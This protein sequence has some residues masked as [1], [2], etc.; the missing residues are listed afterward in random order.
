MKLLSET[1]LQALPEPK[2]LIPG[3]IPERSFVVM[4]GEPGCG[5]TFV[6]LS[7]A[8]SI[9]SGHQWC[10]RKP[11]QAD[12]LYIAGEGAYGLK[13]RSAAYKKKNAISDAVSIRY[14]PEPIHLLK[15][16]NQRELIEVLKAEGFCPGLI[17]FDTLARCFVGGDENSAKDMGQAVDGINKLQQQFGATSLVIH[18][19]GKAG[20]SERG[21]SA[22]RG[23]AD[24][25][26][27]CSGSP[28]EFVLLSCDKMK[29][30][31]PFPDQAFR[32]DRVELSG[33]RS[34]LSLSPFDGPLPNKS[35]EAE[36]NIQAALNALRELGDDGIT[37]TNFC[38][39][40]MQLTG[41][42]KSSFNRILRELK[43]RKLV[44]V[45]GKGKGAR[46]FPTPNDGQSVS[47]PSKCHD[48]IT[49][50]TLLGVTSP[51]SLGGDNDTNGKNETNETSAKTSNIKSSGHH[52][53]NIHPL[54]PTGVSTGMAG[55]SNRPPFTRPTMMKEKSNV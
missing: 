42:S 32:T 20:S 6:A 18:H 44:N 23:A 30:A 35:E 14:V 25:M 41:K 34:S 15:A 38:D 10:S 51:P 37:N 54:R 45:T 21:S 49:T 5:K 22:L 43:S 27:S 55:I 47:V 7:M 46:Y 33:G 1:D 3:I 28:N 31:E 53:T 4:Y 40:F 8:L 50:Q 19:T 13:F 36:E 12:V 11:L 2:W 17:I 16:D 48:T 24:V 29:E 9:A 26:M 52:P 39:A